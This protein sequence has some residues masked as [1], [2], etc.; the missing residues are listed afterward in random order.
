MLI[1]IREFKSPDEEMK[2]IVLKVAKQCCTTNDVE[3]HYIKTE[4]LPHF[5]ESFWNHRMALDR[6]IYRQLVDTTVEIA[7]RVGAAE[8]VERVVDGFKNENEQ[9]RKMTME[10]V[11]KISSGHQQPIRRTTYRRNL[12]RFPKNK[13]PRT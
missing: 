1:L 10:T 13:Q 2:K 3:P 7:N 9:Y 12:L 8:I 11:E 6:H 5:F 4:I